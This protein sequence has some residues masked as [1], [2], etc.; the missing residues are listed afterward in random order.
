MQE[1]RQT[2]AYHRC[3]RTDVGVSAFGQ[4]VSIALRSNV[5]EGKGVFFPENFCREK[6]QSSTTGEIDYPVVLNRVL[7]PEIR[8]LAW[9]PVEKSFSA[10]FSCL[11]RTYKYYFPKGNLK[12]EKMRTACHYLL[13]EHDFRNFC[14]IDVA[15]NGF[16]HCT[17]C[18]TAADVTVEDSG[19]KSGVETNDGQGESDDSVDARILCLTITGKA[20][21]W[22]QIRCILSVLFLIGQGKENPEVVLDLL[23]VEHHPG[24]PQYNLAL[25]ENF[26]II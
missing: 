19:S 7:P 6:A 11:S 13:G 17:R 18:I 3:G 5:T 20:F 23:D 21:L 8:V 9:C 15:K 4:V 26:C 2:A 12:I 25:G 24:K 14:K 22:H 16:A 1:N 10:R